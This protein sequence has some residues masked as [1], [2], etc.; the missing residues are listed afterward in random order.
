MSFRAP[1][2]QLTCTRAAFVVNADI[3]GIKS[4]PV[5]IFK[6]TNDDLLSDDDLAKVSF[7]LCLH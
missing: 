4:T 6:G 2:R 1:K 3:E 5:A 7:H